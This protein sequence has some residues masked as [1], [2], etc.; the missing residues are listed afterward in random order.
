MSSE[1]FLKCFF[2][3]LDPCQQALMGVWGRDKTPH[4]SALSR[5]LAAVSS[6][7]LEPLRSLFRTHLH[8]HG[9]PLENCG[10]L[11]SRTGQR[12]LM[13]DIDGTKKAVRQRSLAEG[14]EHPQVRRH[15]K[16]ACSS[17]RAGRKRGEIIR[18]RTTVIQSHTSEWLGTFGNTGNERPTL[19]LQ[20]RKSVTRVSASTSNPIHHRRLSQS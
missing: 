13:F 8:T 19:G 10:G 7:E 16:D 5:F 3:R 9:T 6:Q 14:D 4:R 20:P 12:H 15:G 1:P 2:E 17:G 11:Y 18:N